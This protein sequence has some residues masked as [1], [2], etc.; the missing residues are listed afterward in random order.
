MTWV[1]ALDEFERRLEILGKA[2]LA[3][4]DVDLPEWEFPRGPIPP[5]VRDRAAALLADAER[6]IAAAERAKTAVQA[7]I[8]SG[9]RVAETLRSEASI[10]DQ[11][12]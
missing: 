11:R 9:V 8:T 1:E 5:D 3:A 2:A 7:E 4:E 12:A 10:L 6:L